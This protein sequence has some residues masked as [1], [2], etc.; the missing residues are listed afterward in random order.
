MP[1][2]PYTDEQKLLANS[3]DL[4]TFLR[5][6][7]E[8][9]VPVGREFK[10][11]YHDGYGKHDSITISGSQWY[12]HK[13]QIGGG[14]IKFMREHYGM[15]F[16][17]AMQALLGHSALPLTHEA[18]PVM[19]KEKKEFRLP[20][21]NDNG[22]E[23]HTTK[24]NPLDSDTDDDKLLDGDEGENGA[25]WLQYGILFEPLRP[26]T[27]GNGVPDGDEVFGQTLEQEI[28]TEDEVITQVTVDM[29]TNGNIAQ[30]LTIESMQD[31]DA[32]SSNVV[33]LMGEPLEFTSAT[34]FDSATITFQID[35]EKL[36][37]LVE[38]EDGKD[39]IDNLIILWYNEEEGI[40]EEMP[41]DRDRVNS[42]VSTTTTH[43][44][45]YLVVDSVK[46]YAA[47]DENLINLRKM[48]VGNTTEY[49]N[50]HTIYLVDCSRGM[51]TDH[52]SLQLRVGY[53]GVTEENFSKYQEEIDSEW[54]STSDSIM[55]RWCKRSTICNN[56]L[57]NKWDYDQAAVI[58]FSDRILRQSSLTND[59]ETL[60]QELI[61]FP[62]S[63][64]GVADVNVALEAARSYIRT[65][66][67]DLYRVVIITNGEAEFDPSA[68][69]AFPSHTS[70]AVVNLI[71]TWMPDTLNDADW[72]GIATVYD[73]VSADDLTMELT[74][75][76]G[77][78]VTTTT[79]NNADSDDDG[80]PNI[81]EQYGLKPNGQPIGTDYKK[82]DTDGDG[83][84][85]GVEC[86]FVSFDAIMHAT[87]GYVK[88]VS[89]LSDP[90]KVDTDGD[91]ITDDK[92]E[93]PCLVFDQRFTIVES[94]DYIPHV[95]FVETRYLKSQECY[96]KNGMQTELPNGTEI[97]MPS[98]YHSDL[99]GYLAAYMAKTKDFVAI[100]N[101]IS[102]LFGLGYD[103]DFGSHPERAFDDMGMDRSAEALIH[104][105]NGTGNL[106]TYNESDTCEMISCSS[107]NLNHL[108]N[109]LSAIMQCGEQILNDGQTIIIST[110]GDS[111]LKATCNVDRGNNSDG[112]AC[113]GQTPSLFHG[114]EF[115]C[116]YKH[117][118]WWNTI[119]ESGTA[120][121]AEISRTGN[122]YSMNYK[123][124]VF[125]IYEWAFHYDKDPLSYIMHSYHETGDAQ[126]YKMTGSFSGTVSWD[127]GETA[128]TMDVFNQIQDTMQYW[129]STEQWDRSNEYDRFVA[130]VKNFIN[131]TG[132]EGGWT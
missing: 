103:L 79:Y 56:M 31:V 44:S 71:S 123:Y 57:A 48:Y 6:R 108:H 4:P 115:Q 30:N 129:Q 61:A 109:N 20:E 14:P 82:R 53:N 75:P 54:E 51:S 91:G 87:S 96:C 8:T 3:V 34:E 105:F 39:P 102:I 27:D 41:T 22:E 15:N 126:E 131:N 117:R 116:N 12:D 77:H 16:Q 122:T 24:T 32:L 107:R 37:N 23:V 43:F 42:T 112:I 118:D 68:F 65:G 33:G 128:Y 83:L 46:W 19:A 40:F 127:I 73:T 25:I 98:P 18:A 78:T 64:Q 11:V 35:R 80:I 66:T 101:L 28:V 36:E 26:D 2:I 90:T 9:L 62:Q 89:C 114:K 132:S 38:V 85:D 58:Q 125:D 76:D 121:V 21:A 120:I 29:E 67:T 7:G 59:M 60:K 93:F 88:Y 81:V 10:L 63:A 84:T 86:G 74:T 47:W 113:D 49:R 94:M 5:M 99:I 55:V 13:N 110:K 111:G 45:Q 95:D 106:L 50:V 100:D 70:I 69:E 130:E 97:K 17:E 104:Y 124:Y 52:P 92:D 72:N 119:G 1:Y